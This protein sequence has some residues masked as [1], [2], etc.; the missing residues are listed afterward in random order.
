[1]LIKLDKSIC[2]LV[3]SFSPTAMCL[4]ACIWCPPNPS[5]NYA[6]ST[7]TLR[8]GVKEPCGSGVQ[9]K[10]FDTTHIP[11][12]TNTLKFFIQNIMLAFSHFGTLS[13]NTCLLKVL[14]LV[15]LVEKENAEN[16]RKSCQCRV[17]L[18]LLWIATLAS[19]WSNL[20]HHLLL[21]RV[22]RSK[23]L[24]KGDFDVG[25]KQASKQG[26]PAVNI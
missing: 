18:Q 8:T 9:N 10:A 22:W 14:N 4:A 5:Q 25:S 17:I 15:L 7:H 26:T 3:T 24:P 23:M 16:G 19:T 21:I 6:E 13:F 1:M 12:C 20:C 2:A 11:D